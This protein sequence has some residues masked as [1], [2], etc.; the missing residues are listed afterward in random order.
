MGTRCGQDEVQGFP[1][2]CMQAEGMQH[3]IGDLKGNIL[4]LNICNSAAE[5]IQTRALIYIQHNLVFK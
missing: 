3:P 5:L 4:P 2:D 1:F